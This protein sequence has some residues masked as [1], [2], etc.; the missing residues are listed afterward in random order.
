MLG[1]GRTCSAEFPGE[2]TIT[3]APVQVKA[4][5]MPLLSRRPAGNRIAGPFPPRVWQICLPILRF[6]PQ[7]RFRLLRSARPASIPARD[8]RNARRNAGGRDRGRQA[9][10]GRLAGG[11]FAHTATAALPGSSRSPMGICRSRTSLASRRPIAES[12]VSALATGRE[13]KCRFFICCW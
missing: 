10:R 13:D 6:R 8:R 12:A 2:P 5:T 1:H 7:W 9:H 4:Y 11:R 3:P